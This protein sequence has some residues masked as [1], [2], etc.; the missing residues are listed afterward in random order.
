VRAVFPLVYCGGK[1][2]KKKKKQSKYQYFFF[3]SFFDAAEVA[4]I[5]QIV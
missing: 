1:K 2:E 4:I 3:P 5:H